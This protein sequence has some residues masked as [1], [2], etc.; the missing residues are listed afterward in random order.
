MASIEFAG[1]LYDDAGTPI[2][3]ATVNLYDR[4]T[5]TPVRATTTTSTTDPVGY[6]SITHTTDGQFDIEFVSGSSKRRVKYDNAWQ[7]QEL[8]LNRMVMRGRELWAKGSD[9]SSASSITPGTD[10]N[11][12]DI[13]GTTTITAI[14]TL[15]AG[16]VVVFQFDAAL[17]I[18]HNGTSLILQ[19]AQDVT[20]VA[21]DIFAFISEGSG[22][23]REFFRRPA[24]PITGL[25]ALA[26]GPAET[27]EVYISDNGVSKRIDVVELLNP[28]NFTALAAGPAETD[29]VFI[30]DGGTGKRIDIVELL[31]PE[32]FTALT[33]G[34][35]ETD[36]V[37]INDGG[38]G[39]KIDVVELLNPEN[40]TALAAGPA[41]D[42]EVFI[43]DGGTGKK[44]A[45]N[46]LLNPENFTA[47][48]L[49]AAADELFINDDGTGKKITH[50]DLLFGAD[51]TPSTQAHSDSAAKGSA[52]DA[53]RSD[54][55]HAMP[56]AGGT[57]TASSSDTFTNKTIDADNN[58]ITNIGAS[59]VKVDIVSGQTALAVSPAT[60]DELLINDGGVIKKI[61]ADD[62]MFGGATTPTTQAHSDSAAKGTAIEAARIDHKHA[63]P[64]AATGASIATGSYTGDGST[65]LGV[66]GVGFTPKLLW[67]IQRTTST[68][69]GADVYMT[70]TTI[71]DDI[72]GGAA[73]DI[74]ED[75]A[76]TNKI[77]SLDSDGFTVDDNSADHRPNT[78]SEVYNYI[79]I[80]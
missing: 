78:A 37:F 22:N 28:E 61:T 71:I 59:E 12:F 20:T 75:L 27:D 51:G 35:A 2:G 40:F 69:G 36:E 10:G 6:Y 17:T 68:G 56:A 48:T 26:A 4:N 77:I 65:S 8:E 30:S 1:F 16:S 60:G 42:D 41:A 46:E 14:A 62:F 44:I 5:V 13:T 47:A 49:P 50:D 9:L 70:S 18:T 21:G 76:H 80:G 63:M 64:A 58:T 23:W 45:I 72:S 25:T 53:A 67:I 3:G 57:V 29:E 74:S 15:Q 32:N 52:L 43:N 54:H 31:N 11:F 24:H 19:G 7:M 66:T 39:K 34:P 73:V 38:T 55:K 33:T 79:A